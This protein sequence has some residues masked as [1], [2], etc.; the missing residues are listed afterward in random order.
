MLIAWQL[1]PGAGP[2]EPLGDIK[3]SGVDGTITAENQDLDLWLGALLE[4]L[5]ALLT[6]SGASIDL[7]TEPSPL[8]FVRSIEGLTVSWGGQ[9]VHA[10]GRT[11]SLSAACDSA[12]A[13]IDHFCSH[14]QFSSSTPLA[15]LHRRLEASRQSMA[16]HPG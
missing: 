12:Q 5:T 13:L 9:V 10:S 16:G 14:P 3:V 1:Y 6:D 15:A 2:L 7:V 4:G 11:G 8:R